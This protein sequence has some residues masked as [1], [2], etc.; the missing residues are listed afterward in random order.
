[1]S[2]FTAIRAVS[3][4]LQ[5]IL[6]LHITD[7]AEPQLTG[8]QIDLRSPRELRQATAT[9]V[10]LWLYRVTRNEDL[11]NQPRRRPAPDQRDQRGMPI[12]LYYLV[13]PITEDSES[14]Q[15]LLGRVLQTFNDHALL[16]GSDL[17]D[18]LA[19]ES[20]ELRL[21]LET[22]SLE[23][24]TRVW[25]AL[26]ESYQLSVSYL[27]QVVV[28]DSDHEPEHTLPVLLKEATYQQIVAVG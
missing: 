15:A 21:T 24:L 26:Q 9:G 4:T 11:L 7:S 16:A 1:M 22:L 3:R 25:S 12:N 27:V 28:L 17:Q 19:G 13:T 10:S 20:T 14:E 5:R 2:E 23:E 18:A 6:R 8:V